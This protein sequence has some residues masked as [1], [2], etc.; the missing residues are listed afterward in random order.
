MVVV[1]GETPC[2]PLVAVLEVHPA[3]ET[4]AQEVASVEVHVNV[5]EFPL[6]IVDGEAVSNTVG[7]GGVPPDSRFSM[8]HW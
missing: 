3:G 7:A 6:V 8:R 1:A 2:E 4:A 5:E